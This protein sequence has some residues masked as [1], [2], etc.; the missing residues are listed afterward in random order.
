M[1]G[2]IEDDEVLLGDDDGDVD[3]LEGG[4]A[5]GVDGVAEGP[6]GALGSVLLGMREAEAS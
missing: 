1:A 2:G 6:D 5:P 4:V 3:A